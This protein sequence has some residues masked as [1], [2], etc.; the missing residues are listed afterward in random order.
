M[1]APT[2]GVVGADLS[3]CS[4]PASARVDEGVI[5]PGPPISGKVAARSEG[6]RPPPGDVGGEDEREVPGE[7][8]YVGPEGIEESIDPEGLDGLPIP[9]P[10][11]GLGEGTALPVDPPSPETFPPETLDGILFPIIPFCS[12]TFLPTPALGMCPADLGSKVGILFPYNPFLPGPV[13]G[14]E[15]GPAVPNG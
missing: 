5:A 6:G 10:P 11:A 12:D 15:P 14:P 3:S 1:V 7:P 2:T 8:E 13:P 9:T 4:S